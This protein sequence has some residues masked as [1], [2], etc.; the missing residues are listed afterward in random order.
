MKEKCKECELYS[1]DEAPCCGGADDRMT[2]EEINEC[3]TVWEPKSKVKAEPCHGHVEVWVERGYHG[4]MIKMKCG[5]TTPSGYPAFCPPCEKKHE[6]R[7][8]YREAIMNGETWGED[9]Y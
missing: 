9:D 4:K 2:N 1:R 8:W 3:F 7:D 6:D 5:S